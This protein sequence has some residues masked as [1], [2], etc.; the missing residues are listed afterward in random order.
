MCLGS[1]LLPALVVVVIK[2]SHVDIHRVPWAKRLLV[3]SVVA[4][5]SAIV[6][7]R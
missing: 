2:L 4:V 5:V 1:S 6:Q 7:K 3:I